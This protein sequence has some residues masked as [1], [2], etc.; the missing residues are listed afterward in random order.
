MHLETI[1][2]VTLDVED[3]IDFSAD[4]ERNA[5]MR[6]RDTYQG[7][8]YQ[9]RFVSEVK[10]LV[11]HS[12]CQVNNV[13]TQGAGII[14]VKFRATC[15][16]YNPGDPIAAVTIEKRVQVLMGSVK[17]PEPLAVSFV[18]PNETI[19]E[20]Q[21]V[22]AQ[23]VQVDY[24][25]LQ[26]RPTAIVK[27]L[28]CPK[29][30]I[31]WVTEGELTAQD[32]DTLRHYAGLVDKELKARADLREGAGAG[33]EGPASNLKT[34]QDFFER[35]LCTYRQGPADV[36]R[37]P[38]D[39]WEGPAGPPLPGWCESPVA[40][41]RLVAAPGPAAGKWVRP[42]GLPLSYPAVCRMKPQAPGGDVAADPQLYK[43]RRLPP[44]AAFLQMLREVHEYLVVMNRLPTVYGSSAVADRHKNIWRIMQ[45][46]QLPPA[47]LGAA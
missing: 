40:L 29:E 1:F 34:G 24:P 12:R 33:P 45:Q 35:L 27:Q 42:L 37:P 4:I 14:N 30:A 23:V 17:E 39:G 5:L 20:G 19:S 36:P 10:E 28:V 16:L 44:V 26:V 25:P 32:V 18:N 8:C 13:G 9:G 7:K 21:L 15:N 6:V 3:L 41:L 2:T 47:T 38:V 22:P 43:E 11:E 46:Q 31:I